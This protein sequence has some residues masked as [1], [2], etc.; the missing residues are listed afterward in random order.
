MNG[1][2]PFIRIGYRQV[3]GETIEE[4]Q[5]LYRFDALGRL[6]RND[7]VA[8]I[9]WTGLPIPHDRI[10]ECPDHYDVH[11]S[12]LIFIGVDGFDEYGTVLCKECKEQYERQLNREKWTLGI[13]FRANTLKERKYD[14]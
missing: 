7:D 1:Q 9:S 8:G 2:F 12:R 14:R 5:E 6:V 11:N 10:D 3:N 13:I 4:T